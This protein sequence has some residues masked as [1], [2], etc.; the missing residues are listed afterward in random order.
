MSEN[1]LYE[2]FQSA[3]K[4]SHSNKTALTHV[5]NDILRSLDEKCV[6]LVLLDLSSAFDTVDQ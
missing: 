3:Y 4:K 2:V 6:L 5:Q 1:N